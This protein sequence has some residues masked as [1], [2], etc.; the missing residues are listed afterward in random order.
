MRRKTYQTLLRCNDCGNLF[1]IHRRKGRTRG[2]GH[3]KHLYCYRC[4][5]VTA[6]TD[7][8]VRPELNLAKERLEQEA[9]SQ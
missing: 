8:G 5:Q 1:P 7:L 3:T 6:H 9:V 4:R 2:Y